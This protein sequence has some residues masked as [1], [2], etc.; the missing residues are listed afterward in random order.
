[1][2]EAEE[3]YSQIAD[4][5][6]SIDPK[7]ALLLGNAHWEA[8]SARDPNPHDAESCRLLSLAA[9][10]Q[11]T[12]DFLLA[13]L[14]RDRA[15]E[16][17][18][19]V[20]WYEGVATV[21]MSKA[22]KALAVRNDDFPQGKTL[23]VIKG[24]AD[25]ASQMDEMLPILQLGPSGFSVG[26]RSPSLEVVRRF[27]HEKRGFLLL[28]MGRLDDARDSYR[29]AADAAVGNP[30]GTVK[31]RLGTALVD[32]M[33]GS[34]TMALADTRSAVADACTLGRDG[35]DLVRDGEYNITVMERG[36]EELR[37]YEIL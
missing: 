33:A 26:D 28:A 14:W 29:R 7:A 30:R 9:I 1:V 18:T 34:R 23:D 36:G 31:V 10:E 25:A 32:Y 12:P 19:R 13:D 6:P 17:F 16:L 2:A 11:E 37:P 15:L 8:M 24:S 20:G 3:L 27:Y 22:F 35:V 5:A 4:L 21:L